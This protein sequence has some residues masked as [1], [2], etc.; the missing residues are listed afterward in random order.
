MAISQDTLPARAPAAPTAPSREPAGHRPSRWRLRRSEWLSGYGFVL[1]IAILFAIFIGYPILSTVY[2]SFTS[3]SGFGVPKF[4][5]GT[6]YLRMLGDPVAQRAFLTTIVY[7]I[8]TTALQTIIPLVIAVLVNSVWKGLSVVVRTI[9][10]IPG[11]VSFVVSGVLWK[12]IYDPNL[13]TLNTTLK[14]LGLGQFATQWLANPAT[15]L[16]AI[17]IVSL[18]GAVGM[19]MLIFFAGLQ[20]VDPSYYEAAAMDGAKPLQQFFYITV[21]SLRVVTAIVVSLNLINGLKTFDI[22]FVMTGGGP[23]HASEV[24]GTYLYNMAFGSTS[25]SIPQFGYASAFSVI[26]M[27]LCGLAVLL[28]VGLARRANR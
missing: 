23:N 26:V 12:L 21:P 16:P 14:Q 27:L 4:T 3:W 25:G 10:F 19:N 1:P 28:Q 2:L 11:V 5:G 24:L 6:N 15:E 9:L 8:V 18:W 17:M 13:G 22:I 7:A 20:G